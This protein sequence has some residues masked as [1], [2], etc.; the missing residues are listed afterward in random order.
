MDFY[1]ANA[2]FGGGQSFVGSPGNIYVTNTS[3]APVLAGI[4]A[5]VNFVV[6]TDPPVT[7]A[8]G[9]TV[10]D[11]D[12]TILQGATIQIS[13]NYNA[14]DLLSFTPVGNITG[15]QV[16]D[17]LTLTG[18]DTLANYQAVLQSVK[19]STAVVGI[20]PRTV[21][22]TVTDGNLSSNAPTQTVNVS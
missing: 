16:G 5:A 22:F 18:T 21:T 9:I 14:A 7:V 4:G 10:T 13:G 6:A 2:T 15:T 12:D 1:T 20:T 8:S 11:A 17:T 3:L 19:F